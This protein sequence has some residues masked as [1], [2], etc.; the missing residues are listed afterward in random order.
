MA[1]LLALALVACGRGSSDESTEGEVIGRR[2]Q[3]K[4]QR[5][6]Q[7]QLKRQRQQRGS[8]N[9][10]DFGR[11]RETTAEVSSLIT[12]ESQT[13]VGD[14]IGNKN[15]AVSLSTDGSML[16][17]PELEG[18]FWNKKEGLCTYLFETAATSCVDAPETFEGYPYAFL[19]RLTARQSP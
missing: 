7:R 11:Q 12:V 8:G 9:R 3:P 2:K 14:V 6:H 13:F 18:H 5:Q 15:P 10:R 4:R 19:G 17:W 16:G 1:L